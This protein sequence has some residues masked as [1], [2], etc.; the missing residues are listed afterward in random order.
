MKLRASKKDK[1]IHSYII[2]S[3]HSLQPINDVL[4]K[5]IYEVFVSKGSLDLLVITRGV[6]L[7]LDFH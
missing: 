7:L 6:A 3:M 2:S 4:T 1:L 5:P